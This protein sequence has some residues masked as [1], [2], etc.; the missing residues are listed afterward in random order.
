MLNL[1]DVVGPFDERYYPLKRLR[2]AMAHA[3]R[4]GIAVHRNFA[5]YDGTVLRGVSRPGPF[6]HVLGRREVLTEWGKAYG[7]HPEWMQQER[8][9]VA[10]YDVHGQLACHLI[11]RLTESDRCEA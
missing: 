11:N 6:L 7:L 9:G 2:E 5:F 3:R 4:G 10:H 1:D 8:D